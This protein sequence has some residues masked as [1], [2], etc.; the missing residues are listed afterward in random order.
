[1]GAFATWENTV[2]LPVFT[3]R[4]VGPNLAGPS[5]GLCRG[6]WA[7]ALLWLGSLC[8]QVL[9]SD[10]SSWLLTVLEQASVLLTIGTCSKDFHTCWNI[11]FPKPPG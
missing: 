4:N 10:P 5:L 3:S 6:F 11:S 2:Y 7:R 1:M 9:G 8:A